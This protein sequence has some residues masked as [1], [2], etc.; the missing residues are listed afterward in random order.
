MRRIGLPQ[1]F[2]IAAAVTM[3]LAAGAVWQFDADYRTMLRALVP[4]WIGI[5][6]V[7]WLL[8]RRVADALRNRDGRGEPPGR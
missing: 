6:A 4:S 2:A 8:W 3:I 5:G 7:Y 1:L